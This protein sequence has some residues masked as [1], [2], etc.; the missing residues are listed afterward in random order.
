MQLESFSRRAITAALLAAVPLA[1]TP[2]FAFDNAL[3]GARGPDAAAKKTPGPP[4]STQ[5]DTLAHSSLHVVAHHPKGPRAALGARAERALAAWMTSPP[6]LA[7]LMSA[8]AR[9]S[10]PEVRACVQGCPQGAHR[11]SAF[12]SGVPTSNR[13]WV[14]PQ[15]PSISRGAC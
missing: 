9:S 13:R 10:A 5:K 1:T 6:A 7:D 11:E 4:R 8:L 14:R 3:P 12:G 2:A 15:S